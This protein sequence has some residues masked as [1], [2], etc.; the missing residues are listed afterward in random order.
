MFKSL[1]VILFP[2]G[3]RKLEQL[4]GVFQKNIGIFRIVAVLFENDGR[5]RHCSRH[6]CHQLASGFVLV[7]FERATL[8]VRPS[9]LVPVLL[10]QRRNTHLVCIN[11]VERFFFVYFSSLKKNHRALVCANQK[12][13]WFVILK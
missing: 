12:F 3:P 1:P 4:F 8:H 9:W 2:V 13:T 7:Q 11:T 5:G 6:L 10:F